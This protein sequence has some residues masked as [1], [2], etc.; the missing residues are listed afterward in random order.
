MSTA[1]QTC[2]FPYVIVQQLT[3]LYKVYRKPANYV[4]LL[5]FQIIIDHPEGAF[6]A[7]D[8]DRLNYLQI[9]IIE[10]NLFSF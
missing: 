1:E 4:M 6:S 7:V 3:V 5:C 8:V 10:V 2:F 9:F